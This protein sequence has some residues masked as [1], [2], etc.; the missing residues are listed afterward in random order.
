[1]KVVII[2]KAGSEGIDFKNIRQIHVMDPWYN[3]NRI[4][5]IIGRGV[6]NMS[7]CALPFE[8]RNVEIYMHSTYLTENAKQE[9]A[10]VYVYRLAQNKA[11]KIGQ[12]TRLMK[13]IAVD[14]IVNIG[15]TNFTVSKMASL[16]ENQNIEIELS[17]D[18]KKTPFHIGD[19]PYSDICDYMENCAFQC[20]PN[21]T[22]IPEREIIE[23]T[24]STQY[25]DSN[26]ERIRE[27][28]RNLF[29]D[30]KNGQS[31]YDLNEIIGYVNVTKQ[32]P[33]TQI[34]AALTKFVK[35]QNEYVA[36]R[37]GRRGNLINRGMIYAFQPIEINDEDITVFERKVPVEYKRNVLRMESRM[38]FTDKSAGLDRKE[39]E[40]DK[41][42][43]L[44]YSVIF[45]KITKN[46]N[47]ATRTNDSDRSSIPIITT[48][49]QNWYRHANRVIKH[50]QVVH[51]IELEDIKGHIIRHNVDF[52]MPDEKLV[53]IA[54]FYTKIIDDSKLE[55]IE[56]VI[57]QY[58]DTKMVRSSRK[59]GFLISTQNK[60]LIYVPSEEDHSKWVNAEPED[61][62]QFELSGTLDE[63]FKVN[64]AKYNQIVGFIDMFRNEKEMVYRLKDMTQMQNNVGTRISGQTPG[65]GVLIRYL[66][67]IIGKEMYNLAQS[68]E[69]MQLGIC[70]IIEI[71]LRQYSMKTK[72][73][74]TWFLDPEKAVYNK[75]A[76]YRAIK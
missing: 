51:G 40:K 20:R 22:S 67:Q 32:Y 61:I 74:S 46:I 50:I 44:T 28:I 54:H 4:E 9:A 8:E 52:L 71:L 65:K 68:K 47:D 15:Q 1:V 56:K 12:V 26:D 48:S 11:I 31:F 38:D 33:I 72:K 30:E 21:V 24:Y 60:W 59:T 3:L 17:S 43:Q 7:H 18:R 29:R 66:N 34:Y 75:I 69:I 42:K 27:R 16:V 45:D 5:Q 6:R 13:E 39:G 25:A 53:L 37:Y 2:S 49:D 57:K 73:G 76:K 62:R 64:H 55:P 58:L 23:T 36:D 63:A 70:V 14:C 19:K 35:N 10:D 41:G